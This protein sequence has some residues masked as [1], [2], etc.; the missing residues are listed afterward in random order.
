VT[1]AQ[2]SGAR[3]RLKAAAVAGVSVLMWAMAPG[4]VAHAATPPPPPPPKPAPAPPPPKPVPAPPKADNP[5]AD[6]PSAENKAQAQ[7]ALKHTQGNSAS[8][9]KNSDQAK[10]LVGKAR[11]AAVHARDAANKADNL[12]GQVRQLAGDLANQWVE[13]RSAVDSVTADAATADSAA[14]D[15]DEA[16]N[17]AGNAFDL[18]NSYDSQAVAAVQQADGYAKTADKDPSAVTGAQNQASLSD[19]LLANSATQLDL[20]TASADLAMDGQTSATTAQQTTQT[21]STRSTTL[22]KA[23]LRTA[24][25]LHPI[26][27]TPPPSS[28]P[29]P[30]NSGGGGST[31]GGS[32]DPG[33]GAGGGTGNLGPGQGSG[34]GGPGPTYPAPSGGHGTTVTY[35]TTGSGHR[36]TG[37][38]G[39]TGTTGVTIIRVHPG[40]RFVPSPLQPAATGLARVLAF[41]KSAT[42]P[43][44]KPAPVSSPTRHA[45]TGKLLPV[46]RQ[47][48]GGS[49]TSLVPRSVSAGLGA[50]PLLM[51]LLLVEVLILGRRLAR[52]THRR[53]RSR[54]SSG[55]G[56]GSLIPSWS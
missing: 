53:R 30:V 13:V 6:N 26:A 44:A 24:S 50:V 40:S 48:V 22:I 25:N 19:G 18:I 1:A 45:P 52:W 12:A 5:K 36:S 42:A 16:A 32:G 38:T 10:G 46:G 21:D 43:A 8:I 33:P 14:Q 41:S 3:W 49:V 35:P 2:I 29:P 27:T 47:Q 4:G 20:V 28:D 11:A 56:G 31:G 9:H 54:G 55:Y 23:A 15:A 39:T 34:S 37:A 17:T 51:I 7:D